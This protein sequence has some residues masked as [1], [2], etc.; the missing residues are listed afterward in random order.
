MYIYVYIYLYICM[1]VHT[2]IHEQ[3]NIYMYMYMSNIN[4]FKFSYIPDFKVSPL[5]V[6]LSALFLFKVPLRLWDT[7]SVPYKSI[8]IMIIKIFIDIFINIMI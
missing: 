2:Y 3:V 1:Y 5:G 4:V 8:S 6:L 7:L